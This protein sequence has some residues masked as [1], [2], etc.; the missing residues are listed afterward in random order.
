MHLG[1]I[2]DGNRRWCA[3]NGCSVDK[4]VRQH[5]NMLTAILLCR[6][7][8][9]IAHVELSDITDVSVYMLSADN[10]AKR[11]SPGD[12]TMDMVSGMLDQLM[13]AFI[14]VHASV[15]VCIA[16]ANAAKQPRGG[17]HLLPPIAPG[18][19]RV[20]V[21]RRVATTDHT[22]ECD[23]RV[24]VNTCAVRRFVE[25]LDACG[26]APPHAVLALVVNLLLGGK[27]LEVEL[28]TVDDVLRDALPLA[29]P[30]GAA[31]RAAI[32]SIAHAPH[33]GVSTL[34]VQVVPSTDGPVDVLIVQERENAALDALLGDAAR[35]CM[36]FAAGGGDVDV[37]FIGELDRLPL[38][39]RRRCGQISAVVSAVARLSEPLLAPARRTCLHIALAYDPV[40]D[41]RRVILGGDNS[42]SVA[43]PGIDLVIRT[44]GEQRSSGFFP[45]HTL[46]SEWVYL[47][48]LFPDLTISR[49]LEALRAFRMRGR[50]Y[51]A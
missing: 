9:Q 16:F 50:R 1:I 27:Q 48:E 8:M 14:I 7:E 29:S 36:K 44:S 25:R 12:H 37:Q 3:G 38:A 42:R 10:L 51:G 32:E 26:G 20:A 13:L 11:T 30:W 15:I 49:L 41:A 23:I 46:Y 45:M 5:T 6:Q 47:S 39:M 40:E 43:Q 18:W 34:R 35:I 33:T 17:M 21:Q 24:C 19:P 2:P 31:V 22:C 28:H 4:L